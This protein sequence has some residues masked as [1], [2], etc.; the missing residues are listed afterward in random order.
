M[1]SF[2]VFGRPLIRKM[3]GHSRP[4]RALISVRLAEPVEIGAP[5]THFLRASVTRRDDG[6]YVALLSGSQSSAV[7]TAMARANAL[8]IVPAECR[9]N[10]AGAILNALPLTD[11]LWTSEQFGIQ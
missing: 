5:L 6:A 4:H 11:D 7:L 8:L 3:L 10:P 9:S 2:E 1:V